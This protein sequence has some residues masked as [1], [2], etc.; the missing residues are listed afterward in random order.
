MSDALVTVAMPTWNTPADYLRAAVDSVLAQDVPLQLVVVNDASPTWDGLTD[1]DDPRLIRYTLEE[2]RGTY[3]AQGLVLAACSTPF[4]SLHDADDWSEPD[5]YARLLDAIDGREAAA[6]SVWFHNLD[7]S[8]FVQSPRPLPVGHGRLTTIARN[9]AHVYRTD[10]LRSV[11]IPSDL[12]GSADT[13]MT[14]LFWH[15]HRVAVVD[16]P[17][18]HYRKW[19]GSLTTHPDTA[20]GSE[21]RRRQRRAR[22][23]RFTA[24]RDSGRPLGG[25]A[26]DPAHVASLKERL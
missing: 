21:W 7:G 13:A 15:R 10:T 8:T 5:R 18:Y 3:Y 6:S 25:Y 11:G 14:S 16:E 19:G 20:L 22:A 26:P 12:R 4:W 17:L 1:Y 23:Q 2:N 24:A 9:H